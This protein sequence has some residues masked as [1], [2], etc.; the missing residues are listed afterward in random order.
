MGCK[1]NINLKAASGFQNKEET[2]NRLGCVK[3]RPKGNIIRGR[4]LE[5]IPEEQERKNRLVKKKIKMKEKNAVK[6]SQKKISLWKMIDEKKW[7]SY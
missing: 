4:C 6:G 3:I 5:R 2:K 1:R 7:K